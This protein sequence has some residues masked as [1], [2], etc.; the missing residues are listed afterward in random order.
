M[1][2][3]QA[4]RTGAGLSLLISFF[5][6]PGCTSS[7]LTRL[8][9][10]CPASSARSQRAQTTSATALTSQDSDDLLSAIISP[11]T[12]SA[13]CTSLCRG[14]SWEQDIQQIAHGCE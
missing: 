10:S 1:R 11:Q 12:D 7:A 13:P 2:P 6:M 3:Q 8:T 9:A 4:L 14:L 5:S